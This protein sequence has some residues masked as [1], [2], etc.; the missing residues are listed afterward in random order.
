LTG[1]GFGEKGMKTGNQN[2]QILIFAL[3]IILVLVSL[4]CGLSSVLAN[5]G[6]NAEFSATRTPMPTFTPTP[7]GAAFVEVA[8]I[9][10]QPEGNES[11][12]QPI[13]EVVEPSPT[14]SPTPEEPTATPTPDAVTVT[15]L[16]NMNVRSGP[17]TNYPIVGAGSAGQSTLVIGRNDDGSWLKI[18]YPSA[19]GTGWIFA[20]L[21]QINGDAEAVEIAQA[22]APP[23]PPPTP[24]PAPQEQA[25]PE[26]EKPKYQFTPTGWHASGNAGIIQFKGRIKD[27]GG[28]LVN[29]FS[30]LVDNWSWGV[31][32]HPSGASHWYPEKGDGEWDV[33]IPTKD[34]GNGL[35]WW[36]LTVVRYDCASFF[37]AG[38]DAQCKQFTRLSEDIKIQVNWP[39]ETIINADWVCHWDCDK[40]LYKDGYRR[41]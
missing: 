19:D 11:G 39:D 1:H 37:E 16:Q 33:V 26:P 31:V 24:A 4:G 3:P 5:S 38:F 6:T 36:Y 29:G 18:E 20:E 13:T 17:G 28:N 10:T 27:E 41:P 23:P 34:L 30:V 25:P 7:E 32:S 2:S 40:G 8:P 14:F 9:N 21:V 22:P 35:G 12:A 15:V